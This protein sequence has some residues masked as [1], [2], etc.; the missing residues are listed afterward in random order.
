M[1]HWFYLKSSPIIEGYLYTLGHM[2]ATITSIHRI[3]A[4]YH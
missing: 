2:V 4:Q 1:I 3:S